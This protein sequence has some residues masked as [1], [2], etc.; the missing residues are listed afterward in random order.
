[1][2]GSRPTE[3][4]CN[5]DPSATYQG[6]PSTYLKSKDGLT[7]TGFGTLMQ[8]FN[9]ANYLGKR[10]QFSANVKAEGVTNWSGLWMRVDHG[11]ESV[12]F[13]NMQQRPIAGTRG[14]QRYSV[15]LD[16]PQEAT[17]I[18]L[19]ILLHGPGAVWMNGG[20]FEVVGADVPTTTMKE[21]AQAVVTQTG[22]G[23]YHVVLPATARGGASI[24]N[25]SGQAVTIANL[26]GHVCWDPS[27]IVREGCNG[28]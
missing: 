14:W 9:A 4:D 17:G 28:P 25:P 18:F 27:P 1:M 20:K 22:V 26:A 19:G 10:I 5:K 24:P 2:A 12:A 8:Q 6:L 11:N 3:Y 7:T 13:D 23:V 21:Q 16:V 15:V